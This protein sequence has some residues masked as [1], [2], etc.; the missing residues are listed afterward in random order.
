LRAKQ[1]NGCGRTSLT[2]FG[3]AAAG[4]TTPAMGSFIVAFTAWL[5]GA[6]LFDLINRLNGTGESAVRR[7]D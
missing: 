5:F 1:K 6:K 2:F 3:A 7:L 4:A